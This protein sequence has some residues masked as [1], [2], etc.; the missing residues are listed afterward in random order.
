M[1]AMRPEDKLESGYLFPI[2]ADN[3]FCGLTAKS[4]ASLAKIKQTKKFR[5]GE[6]FFSA[7]E[8]PCCV[9]LLS[10]GEARI[11]LNMAQNMTANRPIEPNEIVGLTETI[12][13]LPYEMKAEAITPCLCECIRREDF[14][15]FLHDEPEVCFRLV[16]MLGLNLQKAYKFLFF[17]IN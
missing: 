9:Y 12:A 5:E 4:L 7:G 1:K 6:A 14:I 10:E 3:L 15:R 13:N 11:V 16:R 8:M 2:L 17:S